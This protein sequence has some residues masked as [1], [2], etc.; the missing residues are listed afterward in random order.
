MMKRKFVTV[1]LTMSVLGLVGC[2][3]TATSDPVGQ[4]K[5]TMTTEAGQESTEVDEAVESKIDYLAFQGDYQDRVSQRATAVVKENADH[6]SIN[7]E[8]RW[9]SS[10]TECDV[11]L[12]DAAFETGN[13]EKLVY[14]NCQ[15]L[16][17]TYKDDSDEPESV[18]DYIE[19]SG[20][21]EVAYENDHYVLKWTGASEDNCKTC[22]FVKIDADDLIDAENGMDGNGA[23]SDA[24]ASSDKRA[25]LYMDL[26]DCMAQI[27]EVHPGTAGSSLRSEEA[28]G[29]LANLIKNYSGV[30][31]RE[32]VAS[33]AKD[34]ID[35][36][37]EE[38]S[39]IRIDFSECLE[40][41]IYYLEDAHKD[42]A[43]DASYQ[44]FA[45][46]LREAVQE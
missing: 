33:N 21:F 11:W 22:E 18:V 13:D 5:D 39:E 12:M 28:A 20:S 3:K 4:V 29:E 40:E 43:N 34:W 19:E 42:V 14:T 45:D 35:I 15:H 6:D 30:V 32:D 2:G 7:I 37:K 41:V 17:E 16:V 1:L 46:G 9:S 25:D 31:S 36:M 24:E 38:N 26:A 27:Y 8:V 23:A 44:D 10:A